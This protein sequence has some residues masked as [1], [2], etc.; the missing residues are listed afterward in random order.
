MPKFTVDLTRIDRHCAC[1]GPLGLR[2]NRRAVA[3]ISARAVLTA[4]QT[5][6][7]RTPV[8][9]L[10]NR[11]K[12]ICTVCLALAE[13]QLSP[14]V[15]DPQ[16]WTE[17]FKVSQDTEAPDGPIND[18][19]LLAAVRPLFVPLCLGK[20]LGQHDFCLTNS[21]ASATVSDDISKA[22]VSNKSLAHMC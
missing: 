16:H 14:L 13:F 12:A 1:S 9:V 17:A 18:P 4:K 20:Q 5:T 2:S 7:A 10:G 19:Q 6:V 11:L 21:T 3:T 22:I 15:Q 8:E